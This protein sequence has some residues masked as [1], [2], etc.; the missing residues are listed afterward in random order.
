VV[1][2]LEPDYR[3]TWNDRQKTV[4]E[5]L[6]FTYLKRILLGARV[7]RPVY[8]RWTTGNGPPQWYETD[9]ILIYDDH[10][11]VI[12]VKAGAFTY[13][14][15]ATDL[16][17]HIVSLRNLVLN[18]ASQASRFIDYLKSAYEI[19]IC[20]AS[21]REIGRLQR[22]DFRHVTACVITLDP[23]TELAARV[24]HLR[25]VG[26]D[27]G[28]RTVWVLS[29]DNLRVYADL[30][31]NPLVFLHYVE[32]RMRAAKSELLNLN[33]EMDHFGLYIT[34]NN[35]SQ[36]A[37]ELVGG[38]PTTL[39]LVGYSTP[40]DKY[41]DAVVR[42]AA[43]IL[44]KQKMP[45]R[46]AE[47]VDFLANAVMP[48]RSEL[49]SFLL[50]AGAD[51]RAE[52]AAAIDQQLRVNLE[53][54]RPRPLSIYGEMRLTLYTWSPAAPREAATAVEHTRV[55]MLAAGEDSRPLI[56]LEYTAEGVLTDVHWQRV[57][58]VGLS[59]PELDRLRAKGAALREQRVS[60]ARRRGKI[61]PNERCPCGSGRKYKK[62][63]GA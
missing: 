38:Q 43:P 56:E 20:D 19:S 36:Y 41:Y 28:K 12:E 39:N 42:G 5:E 45:Q 13:T 8:Y 3:Q 25:K 63:C 52:L 6:P 21:H 37:A 27:V 55:V 46:L 35:Y 29:I 17:S 14:S 60:A 44:P 10:L 62:C 32:Q 9:G 61:G 47:I 11:F 58:L 30:F 4:S 40:V 48:R 18:P 34:K 50:D 1:C 49:A 16:R 23:F 24:Q 2:R 31:D 15:P 54:R 22:S 51:F 53:L 59:S 57:K 33:D 26:I 7:V